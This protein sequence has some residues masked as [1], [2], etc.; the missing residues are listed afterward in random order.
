MEYKQDAATI[1][2]NILRFMQS[3]G[4]C[5]PIHISKGVS[6]SMLF[7]SA[8]LSELFAEQRV[9]MTNM[10]VGSSPVYFLD[11]Q[12][13]QL[14][15]FAQHLKSKEREAFQIIRQNKFLKDS[16]LEPAIRV[17]LRMIKD[18]A[19]PVEMN[20]EFFWRYYVVEEKEIPEIKITEEPKPAIVE[21]VIIEERNKF[22]HTSQ[23]TQEE[24]IVEEFPEET[25]KIIPEKKEQNKF[26][27][28][29]SKTQKE[30]PKTKKISK[31]KKKDE[32]FFNKIKES[33]S[34]KGI[35]II[36]I[37][38]FKNDEAILRIKSKSK[39]EIL[40]AFNKKKLSDEDIIKAGKKALEMKM[41]FRILSLGETPKKLLELISAIKSLG[42]I[43]KIE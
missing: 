28:A 14:E 24:K 8:F 33:L 27:H 39:E 4:P 36:D 1:K 11:G 2:E 15:K 13:P 7:T 17:A 43:E 32:N 20:G 22:V 10:R 18:F 30:K 35:E 12:E 40:F 41:P 5:L 3:N 9:R 6:Q 37:K 38:D 31:T 21:S 42:N 25:E 29:S 34:K 19:V 26:A 23:K 16:E